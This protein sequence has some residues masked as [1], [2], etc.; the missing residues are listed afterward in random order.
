VARESA[1]V[2]VRRVALGEQLAALREAADMRQGEQ[3]STVFRD[4]TTLLVHIVE[5][6]HLGSAVAVRDSKDP[7]V[8]KLLVSPGA[9]HALG[10]GIGEGSGTRCSG[11]GLSGRISSPDR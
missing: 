10:V 9:W 5:V 2:G 11:N 8:V 4:R 1:D 7:D 3:V 6:A